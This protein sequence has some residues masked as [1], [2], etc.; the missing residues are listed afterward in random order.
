VGGVSVSGPGSPATSIAEQCHALCQCFGDVTSGD[1]SEDSRT[2]FWCAHARRRGDDGRRG[3]TALHAYEQVEEGRVARDD[4]VIAAREITE[5]GRAPAFLRVIAQPFAR[6]RTQDPFLVDLDDMRRR[7]RRV[8]KDDVMRRRSRRTRRVSRPLRRAR[9]H[10]PA[11]D[12]DGHRTRRK[13][14]WER[15]NETSIMLDLWG[16]LD[17]S[18]PAMRGT[19]GSADLGTPV[20]PAGLGRPF[21]LHPG[22]R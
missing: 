5:C 11:L 15:Q 9:G 4:D 13:E 19:G 7:L 18:D 12:C 16:C 1:D 22:L 17:T 21:R 3:S 20:C 8:G 6:E 14:G 10:R 2:V